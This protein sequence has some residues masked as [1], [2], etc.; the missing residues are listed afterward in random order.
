MSL[1]RLTG[2]ERWRA[3]AEKQLEFMAGYGAERPA[4]MAF[5]LCAM[6]ELIYPTK[7]LVCAAADE[8]EPAMLA[9]VR[10]K[11]APELEVPLKTPSSAETLAAGR[12]VHGGLRAARRKGAVYICTGGQCSLPVT[13]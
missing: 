1:A 4:G 9:A 10:A 7:E 11:Y 2:E 6:M 3:A 13:E 8:E 5:A 12:A